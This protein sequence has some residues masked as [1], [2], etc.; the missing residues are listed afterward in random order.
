MEDLPVGVG[1]PGV[2]LMPEEPAPD[3]LH[4]STL[5]FKIQTPFSFRYDVPHPWS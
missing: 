3:P 1:R 5:T 2:V 4:G